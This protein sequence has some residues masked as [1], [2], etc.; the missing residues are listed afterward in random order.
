MRLGPGE[1]TKIRT[2][3]SISI[4]LRCRLHKLKFSMLINLCTFL[5]R[6]KI[7]IQS[8]CI[9]QCGADDAAVDLVGD[10]L[11]DECE[12]VEE[13]EGVFLCAPFRSFFGD[14]GWCSGGE[15]LALHFSG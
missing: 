12:A 13:E 1:D 6:Q 14:F 11:P 15:W 4:Q 2:P 8:D 3:M 7:S 10:C 5:F 9:A